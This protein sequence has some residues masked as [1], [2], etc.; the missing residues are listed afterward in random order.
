MNKKRI[1]E[2]Y[3]QVQLKLRLLGTFDVSE[4]FNEK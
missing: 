3:N 1:K 2:R 4:T